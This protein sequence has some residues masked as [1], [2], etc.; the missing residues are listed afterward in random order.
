M[1]SNSKSV[2]ILPTELL[3]T[4]SN[5][6]EISA[7]YIEVFKQF[8]VYSNAFAEDYTEKE[9]DT[10]DKVITLAEKA[11]TD[12]Y[13]VEYYISNLFDEISLKELI[14]RLNK[15]REKYFQL[16][17]GRQKLKS[18]ISF[19]LRYLIMFSVPVFVL[20][21]FLKLVLNPEFVFLDP[22]TYVNDNNWSKLEFIFTVIQIVLIPTCIYSNKKWG[23]LL[24]N[25]I[26]KKIE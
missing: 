4:I 24:Q 3:R 12:D 1:Y 20:I 22:L 18:A 26:F 16:I 19:G 17:E 14:N 6:T 21:L 8:M 5:R 25:W 15:V 23:G 9:L 11:N 7:D 2:C 10:I 13:D